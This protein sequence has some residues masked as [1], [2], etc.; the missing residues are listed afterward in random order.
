M[1]SQSLLLSK[2]RE[3][4]RKRF[5]GKLPTSKVNGYGERMKYEL[6]VIHNLGFDDYFLIVEDVITE[7]RR[8]NVAVGP[9]RGSVCGSLAGYCLGIHQIN[10][11]RFGLHFERFLNKDRV[12]APDIDTDFEQGKREQVIGY[13]RNKYGD[14]RVASVANYSEL[15]PK[16]LFND[17]GKC[18]GIDPAIIKNINS[19][20]PT[21]AKTIEEAL[22]MDLG[23]GAYIR[24]YRDLFDVAVH[25]QGCI[26]HTGKHAAAV[27]V[28]KRSLGTDLP[29]MTDG[30]VVLTQWDK[31]SLETCNFLKIDVLGLKTLD[32]IHETVDDIG[33]PLEALDDLDLSDKRVMNGFSTGNSLGVFQFETPGMRKLLRKIRSTSFEDIFA[34]NALIRPGAGGAEGSDDLFVKNRMTGVFD[35]MGDERLRPALGETFGLN[36]YQEQTMEMFQVISNFS[37]SEADLIRRA[38]SKK[39]GLDQYR[40]DFLKRAVENGFEYEWSVGIFERIKESDNYSFNKSHAVAYAYLAWQ[41]MYLKLYYPRF[42]MMHALSH[43]PRNSKQKTLEKRHSYEMEAKRLG[44]KMLPFDINKSS[45]GYSLAPEGKIRQGMCAIPGVSENAA[46]SI[47][48][49]GPYRDF[50]DF[51]NRVHKGTVRKDTMKVLINY[52]CFNSICG[53][54][55]AMLKTVDSMKQDKKADGV[56]PTAQQ[57]LFE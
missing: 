43:L 30:K 50:N 36:L 31:G 39:K 41:C 40:E 8:S 29:L 11:M 33:M 57:D 42:F 6:N 37:L 28:G 52:G 10:P 1:D 7:S 34:A 14:D 46:I 3:G 4:F 44:V 27:L 32:I 26:R 53:D 47:K 38:I 19:M 17:L 24:S 55:V 56:D 9:G 48:Q 15:A 20:I 35:C 12:S 25:L 13:L 22:R 54:R 18:M 16:A 5:S 2:C 49:G 45:F 21:K 51:V 23:L